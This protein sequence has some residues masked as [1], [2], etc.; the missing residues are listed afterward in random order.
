MTTPDPDEL[1]AAAL[2][3]RA[4]SSRDDGLNPSINHVIAAG[5]GDE[6][7]S[8]VTY[9]PAP[10]AQPPVAGDELDD[11]VRIV[12]DAIDATSEAMGT[13]GDVMAP[14][15]RTGQAV[16]DALLEAGWQ[17]PDELTGW[18]LLLEGVPI[19]LLREHPGDVRRQGLTVRPLTYRRV[20]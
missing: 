2:E 18:A 5:A 19:V 17:P 1:D 9:R 15:A 7:P 3:P 11:A 16:V 13:Y 20:W 12:E 8:R 4:T 6:Q 10:T 14:T